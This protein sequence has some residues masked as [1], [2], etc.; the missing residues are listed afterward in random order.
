MKA[1][2]ALANAD[3]S[4]EKKLSDQKAEEVKKDIEK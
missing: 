1:V 3:N 2:M 4:M